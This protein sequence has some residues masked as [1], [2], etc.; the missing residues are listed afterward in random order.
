M[1]EK[2]LTIREATLLALDQS[3]A[4]LNSIKENF[5]RAGDAF[6]IANDQAGLTIIAQDICPHV[7]ALVEFCNS[8]YEAHIVTLGMEYGKEIYLYNNRLKDLLTR[9][10]KETEATNFTEVGD[11]L[12]F[13]FFDLINELEKFFAKIREN[14]VNSK[15]G[16]LDQF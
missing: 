10:T 14:F 6:D 16:R 15:D 7:C 1:E 12:R 11:L 9:L 4:A 3:G 13:D 5:K 2:D 8:L